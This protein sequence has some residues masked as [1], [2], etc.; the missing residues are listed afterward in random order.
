MKGLVLQPLLQ[1]LTLSYV[2]EHDYYSSYERVVKEIVAERLQ[3]APGAVS[4]PNPDLNG[5]VCSN[6][7]LA[8]G[9][10]ACHQLD[11]V[12]V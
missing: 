10:S 7:G 8:L 9:K 3:A 6:F 12:R 11:V 4:V 5:W 2:P 1:G